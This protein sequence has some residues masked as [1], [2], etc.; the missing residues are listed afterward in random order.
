MK[1]KLAVM[2]T[3]IILCCIAGCGEKPAATAQPEAVSPEATTAM[4]TVSGSWEDGIYRNESA[5]MSFTA[6]E[7]WTV[8]DAESATAMLGSNDKARYEALA[9]DPQN[10]SSVIINLID[11]SEAPEDI[12]T[13]EAFI[14]GTLEGLKELE[15][16][17]YT[18][19][20]INVQ[21]LGSAE[22]FCGS[23][24]EQKSGARQYYY[25]KLLDGYMLQIAVTLFE[26]DGLDT[27][28]PCFS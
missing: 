4:E 25:C 19:S 2:L 27:I 11:M 17:S 15:N 12:K 9:Y 13:A 10:N 1:T 28:K 16:Y 7:G 21:T 14:A 3:V 22:F 20:G 18:V 6:P 23:A 26:G 24:V 5:G 8:K